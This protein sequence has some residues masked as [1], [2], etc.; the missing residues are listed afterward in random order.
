LRR[1]KLLEPCA[2]I[3]AKVTAFVPH[4]AM[5]GHAD[6]FGRQR[7]RDAVA[8]VLGP[9][10]HNSTNFLQ[11]HCSRSSSRKPIDKIKDERW[12]FADVGKK[13]N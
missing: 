4:Y 3:L 13:S 7:D 12:S 1:F 2:N 11:L 10:I 9:A 5:S 6:L 8:A